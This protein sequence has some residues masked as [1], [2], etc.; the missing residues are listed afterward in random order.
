MLD[1]HSHILFGID[2]GAQTLEESV[3]LAQQAVKEGITHI[4]ATPHYKPSQY[5]NKAPKIRALVDLLQMELDNRGVALTVFPGQEV[6]I[7]EN[8]LAEIDAGDIQFLDEGNR[9]VLIEF[10]TLVIPTYTQA[11]FYEL[12]SRGI[13]PVIAHPERN[14]KIIK[15]ITI[16]EELVAGGALAQLTAASLIGEFGDDLVDLSHKM[17][18][19]GLVHVI[20]SDAHNLDNRPFYMAKAFAQ[21]DKLYGEKMTTWLQ[22]NAKAICNGEPILERPSFM[23]KKKRFF[24]LF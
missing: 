6:R 19:K 11:L 2:D 12:Q 20:A 10:P 7:S 21:V 24:G 1:L 4:I 14:A 17:L 9:Y 5:I 18:E 13:V 3:A 23:D 16:L 8:L 22:E 15:D